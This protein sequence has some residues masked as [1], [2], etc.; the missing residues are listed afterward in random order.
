MHD[1]LLNLLIINSRKGYLYKQIWCSKFGLIGLVGT[2]MF[3]ILRDFFFFFFAVFH[4]RFPKDIVPMHT[5]RYMY[6]GIVQDQ[7]CQSFY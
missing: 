7:I 6:H 5:S 3:Q 2:K 4:S 1:A